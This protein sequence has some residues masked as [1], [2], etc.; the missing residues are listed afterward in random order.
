MLVE[1][2]RNNILCGSFKRQLEVAICVICK[3]VLIE[4]ARVFGEQNWT[5]LFA[6]NERESSTVR[7]NDARMLHMNT[8]RR[9][10]NKSGFHQKHILTLSL[11]LKKVTISATL[12]TVLGDF[13]KERPRVKP[14]AFTLVP[15]QV[16]LYKS[17]A[18]SKSHHSSD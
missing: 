5:Y 1:S 4:L 9:F 10:M 11:W 3:S 18:S 6:N 2:G 15:Q 12:T 13:C 17:S 8:W 7:V 14:T 16:D